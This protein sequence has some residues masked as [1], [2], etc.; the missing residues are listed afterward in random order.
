MSVR[1]R[2]ARLLTRE[3][4]AEKTTPPVKKQPRTKPKTRT[5]KRVTPAKRLRS[6]VAVPRAT[7]KEE[8]QARKPKTGRNRNNNRVQFEKSSIKKLII[9]PF[10][11]FVNY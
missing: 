9:P 10:P 8:E 3:P 6:P 4:F 11:E 2:L 1:S 7:A 5:V